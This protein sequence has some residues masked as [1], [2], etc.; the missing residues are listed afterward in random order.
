MSG[1]LDLNAYRRRGMTRGYERCADCPS[2]RPDPDCST[3]GG[4]GSMGRREGDRRALLRHPDWPQEWRSVLIKRWQ[5]T[6]GELRTTTAET[7]PDRSAD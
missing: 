4:S 6:A 2:H 3:C 7:P 5:F 1:G